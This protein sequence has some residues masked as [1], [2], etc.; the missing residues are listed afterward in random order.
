MHGAVLNLGIQT[1]ALFRNSTFWNNSGDVGGVTRMGYA[2][3]TI[4]GSRFYHNTASTK[5]AVL[6]AMHEGNVMILES[7]FNHNTANIQG[8]AFFLYSINHVTV[9]RSQFTG[10]EAAYGA[11]LHVYHSTVILRHT[12]IRENKG[13]ISGALATD[14]CD[15]SFHG[16]CRMMNNTAQVGGAITAIATRLNMYDRTTI[17]H[18]NAMDIGGGA[19]LFHSELFCQYK[20]ILTFYG[21][22]AS[23]KGGGVNAVSSYVTVFSNDVDASFSLHFIKNM[24]LLGGGIYLESTARIFVLKNVVGFSTKYINTT[25]LNFTENSATHGGAIYVADETNIGV[26]TANGSYTFSSDLCFLQVLDTTGIEFS[27]NQAI[28]GS[29][30]YGG[31]L[32]R[33]WIIYPETT[34][35]GVTFFEKVLSGSYDINQISSGPVR[36]CFCNSDGQ[37]D[38][39][40]KQRFVNVMKG[41]IFTVPVVAVDQVN[42]TVM[43]VSIRNYLKYSESGLGEGQMFQTTKEGCT[44]LKFSIH[45]LHHLEIVTLYAEGPCGNASK[46]Q[47]IVSVTFL[48]CSCQ[49]GFQPKLSEKT[50]CMCECDSKLPKYVTD[51]NAQNGTI[52]RDSNYWIAY[53]NNTESHSGYLS[54]SHCPLDYCIPSNPKVEI[55]LNIDSGTNTQCANDRS[56]ILCGLC[57]PGHSLSIGS[58]QCIQCSNNWPVVCAAIVIVGFLAGIALVALLMM[59]NLTVAIG[60]LNGLIFFANVVGANGNT[61]ITSPSFM[62]F[63]SVPV[64]WLNLELGFNACFFKGMTTYWKTWIDLAF[65]VYVIFLVIFIICVGEHSIRFSRLIARRNPVATLATLVLFS[66]TKLPR[67]VITVLSFATLEYP[68]G[69]NKRVWLPDASVE[70]LSGRHVALFVVAVT[71]LV[72]GIA[73]TLLLFS[74]QWLLYYQ[75]RRVFRRVCKNQRLCHF[76]EPYHA[77]YSIKYRYWTGLLLLVRIAL[78]LVFALNVSGDPGVNLLATVLVG[79]GLLLLKGII[80]N[81]LYKNWIVDKIETVSYFNIVLLSGA[82]FFMREF[83]KDQTV[84]VCI[85]IV[86]FLALLLFVLTYHVFTEVCKRLWKKKIERRRRNV[87]VG[88]NMVNLIDYPPNNIDQNDAPEPTFTIINGLPDK[89]R[90]LSPG[91]SEVIRCADSTKCQDDNEDAA[92]TISVVNSSVPLLV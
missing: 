27:H 40:Q 26:C 79:S 15:V 76:F 12:D 16:V 46:S 5:G 56:G 2:N 71:I 22:V 58:S 80:S 21:N 44:D 29:T 17:I 19:Y 61:L 9:S 83:G 39:K 8:G 77:P 42:H 33:C 3:L 36:V 28:L 30:L 84:T 32:D 35:Y 66:Y 72:V 89:D 60:T 41:E 43:N 90:A 91:V 92:S 59:L 18:N 7:E 45:S 73:Y 68:D 53:I 52:V 20:G 37:P 70:Y 57:R 25:Y 1:S 62:K 24:A 10:N 55:N 13:V 74:W 75:N 50:N 86:I 48:N 34:S 88:G 67:K 82:G 11:V 87:D 38:C 63:L 85:S 14:S 6:A 23:N 65:P 78:Y 54:Y 69:S 51:C 31:L 64:S 47:S 49:V 81:Q 4:D